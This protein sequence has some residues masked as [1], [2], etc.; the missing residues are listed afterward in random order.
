M[1][2]EGKYVPLSISFKLLFIR[3]I[4]LLFLMILENPWK[5]IWINS[6]KEL[7]FVLIDDLHDILILKINPIFWR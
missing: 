6:S 5:I 1:H 2:N 4:I 3:L 7:I